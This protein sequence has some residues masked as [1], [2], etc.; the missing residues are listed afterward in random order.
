MKPH[1]LLNVHFNKILSKFHFQG[2]IKFYF[3]PDNDILFVHFET[4]FDVY[5]AYKIISEASFEFF[6]SFNSILKT[7]FARMLLFATHVCHFILFVEPSNAFDNS[8]ISIFKS[9]RVIREKYVLKFL[10]K[11]LK[12]SNVASFLGKE[13]RLCSPRF[14]FFFEDVREGLESDSEVFKYEIEYEDIIYKMLRNDFVIT[15]STFNSLFSIPRN[16]RFLYFNTNDKLRVDP[17]EEST[18]LLMQYIED[19]DGLDEIRPYRGFAKNYHDDKDMKEYEEK[20]SRNFLDL[21]QE[22]VDEAIQFGFDDSLGRFKGKSHFVRPTVKSWYEAF[23]VL[24]KIFVENAENESFEPSDP[25]YKSYLQNFHKIMDIDEQFFYDATVRAYDSAM[26]CYKDRLPN[27]YSKESHSKKLEQALETYRRHAKGPEAES[28]EEK[29]KEECE[30]FWTSGKQL[31]EYSSLR[32]N[33]CVK[34]KH[35]NQE[36][37]LHSSGIIF[38]STCNCGKTQGKREDPYTIRQANFE[39]YNLMAISCSSCSKVESTVAFPI[40]QPSINDFK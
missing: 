38:V 6:L 33:P 40:F 8:Y 26:Q 28:L 5:I 32:G 13:G 25:D 3:K 21:I 36:P 15:N 30:T 1:I 27:F 12:N 17:I 11:L 9:L 24:H 7:K 18:K 23:K 19:D 4:T 34:P 37:N 31:C 14:I 20:P 2:R 22:H 39:F 35:V 10:P 29:L 16:K